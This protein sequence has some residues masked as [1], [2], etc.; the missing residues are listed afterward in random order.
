VVQSEI[1][2]IVGPLSIGTMLFDTVG[3]YPKA[4]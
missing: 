2:C 4:L 3:R 1:Q